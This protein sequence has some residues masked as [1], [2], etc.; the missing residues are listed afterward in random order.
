MEIKENK[1]T[2]IFKDECI[3]LKNLKEIFTFMKKSK[4]K[5]FK[6][7]IS[8]NLDLKGHKEYYMF[9]KKDKVNWLQKLA[10]KLFLIPDMVFITAERKSKEELSLFCGD[11]LLD[12]ININKVDPTTTY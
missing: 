9:R 6:V 1:M 4:K 3:N 7:T 8:D 5:M 11:L 12:K 10:I 2:F